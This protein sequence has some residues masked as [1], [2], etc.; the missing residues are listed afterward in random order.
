MIIKQHSKCEDYFIETSC[1]TLK[2][3][4]DNELSKIQDKEKKYFLINL[5]KDYL[6]NRNLLLYYQD[7]VLKSH[8]RGGY[9]FD[10]KEVLNYPV[11]SKYGMYD[12][13]IDNIISVDK[14]NIDEEIDK[15]LKRLSRFD[16]DEICD[17]LETDSSIESYIDNNNDKDDIILSICKILNKQDSQITYLT[18]TVK[19]LKEKNELLSQKLKWFYNQYS[20]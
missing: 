17:E 18:N 14:D 7:N 6:G 1:K 16:I 8:H 13:T 12:I 4:I 10:Y 19:E 15:R 3:F 5:E 20:K 2:E 11:G 9:K